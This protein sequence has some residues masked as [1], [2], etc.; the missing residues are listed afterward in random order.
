MSGSATSQDIGKVP[1][2]HAYNDH[3]QA[4]YNIVGAAMHQCFV[5]HLIAE[6]GCP[7]AVTGNRQ[8]A[9]DPHD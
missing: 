7:Q 5:I 3:L 8:G 6:I 1:F 4:I 9:G 2:K